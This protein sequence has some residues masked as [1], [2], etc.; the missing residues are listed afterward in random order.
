M[1]K[2]SR[3]KS[4]RTSSI[5]RASTNKSAVGDRPSVKSDSKVVSPAVKSYMSSE[6]LAKRYQYV[7][8]DLKL[9]A[10]IAIPMI[11][12]LIILSLFV[13]F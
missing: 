7:K 4:T 13:K 11:I 6:E 9:V 10:M 8:D 5:P 2:K 12:G 3:K 1:S